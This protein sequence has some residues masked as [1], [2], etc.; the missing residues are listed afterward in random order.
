[1]VLLHL[2]PIISSV[3]PLRFTGEKGIIENHCTYDNLSNCLTHQTKPQTNSAFNQLQHDGKS[4]YQY[5]QNGNLIQ[6]RDPLISYQYDA[7]NRLFQIKTPEKQT[8][9]I[10]DSFGRLLK[11]LQNDKIQYLIYQEMREIGSWQNNR[12]Q[13]FRCL[14]PTSQN[15]QIFAIEL[16]GT[17][18]F[19]VQ[20]YRNTICALQTTEGALVEYQHHTA[21]ES[22]GSSILGN[23]W[24]FA[25]KRE[26]ETLALFTHRF[27]HPQMRRWLTKDPLGFED[28][29]HLYAYVHN[30]PLRYHDSDGRFDFAIPIV[31]F[32]FSAAMTLSSPIWLPAFGVTV[33]SVYT[34]S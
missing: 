23:L 5:D 33:G 13:E 32:T 30:N 25:N 7:L 16:Q 6:Q 1:M 18:Y 9:L 19:P 31:Q 34:F 29:L 3:H 12:M 21:F 24:R 11:I 22:L 14:H 27:Y 10:Y 26:I 28:G 17:P 2:I 4:S 15:E 20:D 8:Q